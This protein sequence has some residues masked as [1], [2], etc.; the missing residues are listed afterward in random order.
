MLKVGHTVK[1]PES[2]RGPRPNDPGPEIIPISEELE[3]VP[4]N[5]QKPDT[6][7]FYARNY[8]V[9][10]HNVEKLRLPQMEPGSH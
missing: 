10:S 4:G 2:L 9:E 8:P 6:V 3:G 5:P 7:S 1:V